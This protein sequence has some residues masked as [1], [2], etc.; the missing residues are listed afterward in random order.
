MLKSANWLGVFLV[1]I[2]MSITDQVC[3][4]GYAFGF[5]GGPS[6]AFQQ[7]ND[8]QRDP[9]LTLHGN[10]FIESLEE[11]DKSSVFASLGYHPRGA[12][13]RYRFD[14]GGIFSNPVSSKFIFRNISLIAGARQKFDY[15][16]NIKYFYSLGLRGEYTVS[17]NL[18]E[19][20]EF[21]EVNRTL[22][23]PDN[24][25]VNPVVFGL[26]IGGG[27]QYHF[28]ELSSIIVELNVHPDV[29]RQYFQPPIPNVP[30]PFNPGNIRDLSAR[31]IRNI[32]IEL[33][34]GLRFLNKYIYVD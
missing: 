3:A 2:V 10:I 18:D 32:T 16:E 33:S 25:F 1:L 29:T 5:K 15:R 4:Q 30:D 23:F 7:W 17:T 22:F 21:N 14:R 12:A 28:K 11:E 20:S 9:L 34:V 31:E 13:L 6:L 24:E 8:F 19:Y 27:V 26:T